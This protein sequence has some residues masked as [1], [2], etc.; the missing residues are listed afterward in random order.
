[1]EPDHFLFGPLGI[2]EPDRPIVHLTVDEFECLRLIDIDRLTQ[3]EVAEQMKIARP[4]VQRIYEEARTKATRMLVE[5]TYLQISGGNYVLCGE[6]CCRRG[7]HRAANQ[8]TIIT[9]EA[10]P[11]ES[12]DS[13]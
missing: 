6:G 3:E 8:S 5:G 4:T 12:E 13:K 7:R 1:M 10:R 9:H 2:G 11:H